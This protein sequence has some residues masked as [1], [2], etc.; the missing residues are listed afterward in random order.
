MTVWYIPKKPATITADRPISWKATRGKSGCF[1]VPPLNSLYA[2]TAPTVKPVT[3][4]QIIPKTALRQNSS[5]VTCEGGFGFCGMALALLVVVWLEWLCVAAMACALR[6]DRSCL[7]DA[8]GQMLASGC[9]A[10]ARARFACCLLVPLQAASST[11]ITFWRAYGS[12]PALLID[13]TGH[14]RPVLAANQA[15]HSRSAT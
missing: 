3:V 14:C 5:K 7:V 9:G 8:V 1:T 12:S 10:I 6:G 13:S 11:A 4:P 2:S 15:E